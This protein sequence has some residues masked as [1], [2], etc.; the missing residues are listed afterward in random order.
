MTAGLAQSAKLIRT[1]LMALALR[2]A[3][4][5]GVLR[6]AGFAQ[7]GHVSVTTL[8]VARA[9]L[10]LARDLACA[11]SGSRR[12]LVTAGFAQS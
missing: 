4:K 2:A 11:R 10:L 9:G 7:S 5:H 3:R 6:A 1:T 8:C 12:L